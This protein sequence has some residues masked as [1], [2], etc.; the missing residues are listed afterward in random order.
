MF[1]ELSHVGKRPML[2]GFNIS[3]FSVPCVLASRK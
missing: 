3:G 2:R 1:A